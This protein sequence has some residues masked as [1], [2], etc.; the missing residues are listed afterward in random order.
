MK[1]PVENVLGMSWSDYVTSAQTDR[2]IS[3]LVVAVGVL[4]LL[5]ALACLFV[6]RWGKLA[7]VLIWAGTINLVLL[8]A[9][10]CKENFFFAGQFF[11]YSLQFSAP[12][13]F[14]FYV[15]K[16]GQFRARDLLVVKL[17]IAL[18]FTSH[19]LYA[20]AFYPRPG[21]FMVM[22]MNI[23]HV[24]EQ[25]AARFLL[26]AGILDFVLSLL[27]FFPRRWAIAAAL[28]ATFWGFMTTIA[29]MWAFFHWEYWENSLRMW[30]HECLYRFPHFLIPLFLLWYLML[31][32]HTNRAQ[33]V[34]PAS[35]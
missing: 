8:A 21:L 30:T 20:V 16:K 22:T 19:G 29:R 3:N 28:Y 10:Y 11:E 18:T 9:L 12:I 14:W 31:T 17:L 25:F 13:I 24:N 27:L 7:S 5:S 33:K 2:F 1:W 26:L 6:K 34:P 35:S 23:L 4:Y 32:Y 15:R